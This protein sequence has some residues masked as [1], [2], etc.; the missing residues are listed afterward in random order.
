MQGPLPKANKNENGSHKMNANMNKTAEK[1]PASMLTSFS[2]S[3]LSTDV[4]MN[5][6]NVEKDCNDC[7]KRI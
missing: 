2:S 7:G 5:N 6:M 4:G 1:I 3:F